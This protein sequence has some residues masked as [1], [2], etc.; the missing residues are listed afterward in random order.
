M[1]CH[2]E[3]EKPIDM[4]RLITAISSTCKYVPEILYT[5]DFR[6]AY[7]VDKGFTAK[8]TIVAE[9][10]YE[11]T[12]WDLDKKPQLQIMVNNEGNK[13]VIGM[14]HIL[15]DGKGF[16]QYL[17]LMTAFYNQKQPDLP[18]ENCRTITPD[19]RYIHVGRATQQ[20]RYRKRVTVSPLRADSNENHHYC[21]NSQI[22]SADFKL[23]NA[24]TK[25]SQ[26]TLNDV[27]IT[28]YVRVIA[29]LQK[30]KT[31]VIPCPADLR[32][33]LSVSDKLSIANM[34]GIYRRVTIE[35]E[36]DHSFSKTLSQVHIEMELQKSR[37]RCFSGIRILEF[38]FHKIPRLLLEQ[39]IKLSYQLMPVSYTNFGRIDH[40]KLIFWDNRIKSC[41]MTGTYRLPPDFQLSI[42]TFENMCTL[43]CAFVGREK[44]KRTAQCILEEVKSEILEWVSGG[45]V[46]TK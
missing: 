20:T 14:S 22:V 25:Q 26:V 24:M 13:L 7:F 38:A 4:N 27:F 43:N 37:C 46:F 29:H 8:D 41:Y 23:L 40:E 18:L 28:A 45:Y 6:R 42:S 9:Q 39:S 34:T 2:I 36:P 5:Y 44:D 35:I 11:M 30:V 16:L 3:T 17:Y 32:R 19:L 10:T 1:Y 31:V 15:S 21:L 33:F 12:Q